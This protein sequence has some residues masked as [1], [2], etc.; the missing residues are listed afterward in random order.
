MCCAPALDETAAWVTV[1][2]IPGR[3]H[4]GQEWVCTQI[5]QLIH[6]ALVLARPARKSRRE[7][8]ETAAAPVMEIYVINAETLAY[9]RAVFT[10]AV[11]QSAAGERTTSS[12]RSG[13]PVGSASDRAWH[14]ARQ[15]SRPI[16]TARL[17]PRGALFGG[18]RQGAW[19][20]LATTVMFSDDWPAQFQ[21]RASTRHYFCGVSRRKRL[22]PFLKLQ[23]PPFTAAAPPF[24]QQ[25]TKR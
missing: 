18:Q 19:A 21:C 7:L 22:C 14:S 3:V 13:K 1:R 20:L 4:K 24:A 2:M 10:Q 16:P 8:L 23:K 5:R 12:L 11:G 17:P 6:F 15:G 9:M 25:Q